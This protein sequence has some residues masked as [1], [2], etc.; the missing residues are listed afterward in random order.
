MKKENRSPSSTNV[1]AIAAMVVFHVAV[2]KQSLSAAFPEHT[3]A[4]GPKDR[5]FAQELCYG[6]IRYYFLLKAI[7]KLL[8][9]SPLKPNDLD[10]EC[11]I[12]VG[13]YQI[14]FTRVP[15]YAAVSETVTA[16]KSLKK[17]WAKGL[18]NKILRRVIN[19]KDTLLT[20]A[21]RHEEAQFSHPKWLVD[22][23]KKTYAEQWPEILNANNS[24]AP[25]FLRVNSQ[26]IARDEYIALLTEKNIPAKVVPDLKQAIQLE[27]AIPV[28]FL[29]G[30]KEGF[31]SV[32]DASGQW[33]ETFLDLKPKHRVLDACAAPGSKSCHI[34][35]THPDLSFFA[36]IDYDSDRLLRVKENLTRL[37]IPHDH[38][39][40]IL[41]DANHVKQ[42]W[43]GI[44]FDRIL[45]DAPCSST[46]VIRRH[47]DIKLLRQPG[48]I[49]NLAKQQMHLLKALW[50]LLAK[51][52]KLLYTTCSILPEENQ[53]VIKEFLHLHK[54][55]TAVSLTHPHAAI[56]GKHGVQ[57]LPQL[58][59]P[60][61]FFYA[62][63]QK[64]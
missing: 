61:G 56:S 41:A 20:Q 16:T 39:H 64:A 29:P 24:P 60:D 36:A 50:P 6:S 14:L 62:L 53:A 45:V 59:G 57:C 32:Q 21:H 38:V 26:K 34:L 58:D 49:A 9:H 1:R 28:S 25:L 4:L 35:E 37:E 17:I 3:Q 33:V 48:D 42:W 2:K 19:E 5:A 54:D 27:E 23:I 18:L 13:I 7:A 30:F 52:G 40:L 55:A 8:L 15:E 51:N 47:P 44:P 10:V 46:G 31:C 63:L 43:D 22:I 12:L 11:L